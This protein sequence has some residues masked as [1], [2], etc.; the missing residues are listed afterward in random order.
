MKKLLLTPLFLAIL[1]VSCTDEDQS[2][3]F[4]P[5]NSNNTLNC[6]LEIDSTTL[7][8]ICLDGIDSAGANEVIIF[9]S[10]FYS[11]NDDPSTCEFLWNI[12]SGRMQ[13]LNVEKAIEGKIAKSIATIQFNE[14]FSGN[15]LIEVDAIN[16]S[17]S[18]F[19]THSIVLSSD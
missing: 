18:G 14:D 9:A 8:A 5:I 15:G 4:V 19:A 16:K 2:A 13:I 11:A 6:E 1:L 3:E 12:E 17:G 10:S 7:V